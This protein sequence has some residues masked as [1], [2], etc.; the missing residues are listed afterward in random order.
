[1][2]SLSRGPEPLHG[3]AQGI[4]SA[5]PGEDTVGI[6][7]TRA[8]LD[9]A[10]RILFESVLATEELKQRPWREPDHESESRALL[11]LAHHLADSPSTILQ[12]LVN[13]A[14]ET[15][16]AGSAG[17][18]LISKETG[19]FYWPAIAGAWNPHVGGGTPRHFGPCAVVLDADTCQLFKHPE[20]Y[21]PYLA[22]ATP[23]IEEVLL[24]PFHVRGKAV[25]TVWVVSHDPSRRFDAEDQRLLVSLSTF[26]SA[27]YQTLES[28]DELEERRAQSDQDAEKL[29]QSQSDLALELEAT[30]RLQQLGLHLATAGD[31]ES[32]YPNIMDAAIAIMRADFASMQMLYLERGKSGELRLLASRGYSPQAVTAWEWIGADHAT[33]CGVALRTGQRSIVTDVESCD[34]MAGTDDLEMYRQTGVRSLQSTPLVSRAGEVLGMISTC[35]RAPHEPTERDLRLLDLLA[36]QAADWIERLQG[37]E[38]LRLSRDQI[39]RARDLAEA[40]LRTSPV[41]LLVLNADLSVA[42]ANEAFYT[43][44]RV[45]PEETEGRLIYDLGNRQW[46]IPR[47]RELLEAVLPSH[48]SFEGFEVI[49]DFETIGS[50]TMLLNARRMEVERGGPERIILVI[51]DITERKRAEDQVRRAT[52]SMEESQRIARIGSW[53]WDARTDVTSGSPELMRIYGFDPATEVMPDF[54]NQRGLCYPETDWEKINDAV[55]RTLK[56]GEGY[57]LDVCVIRADAQRIW[58]TARSEVVRDDAG[59]IIGLRGTVQDITE[60]KRGEQALRE[61]EERFR[62]LADNMSQLAWTCD[63]FGNVTWYNKRW[64]DY[65][66]LLFDQMKGWDWSKVQHPDHLAR[67]VAGVKRSAETG[68]PWEDTFP[69]RGKDGEYRWFLSRALPI[70]NDAGE[71]VCWFGTNTDVTRLREI[72][73]ALDQARDVAENASRAK[74]KFLAVL[75]HELRTPLTPVLMGVAAMDMNPDLAPALRNDIAMIRRNVELEA[76]L[77]DDLLDLSR[78]TAGKLRLN[79]ESV[80]V[81]SAVRH[82]CETCRPFILEKGIHLHCDLPAVP[83]FVRADSARLQQVLWNLLR[84]SAKFTPERGDIYATI[85]K[86]EDA[87]VRIEVRDTGIGIATNVLPKVFDAFEQGDTNVTKQFGGMGLG[88]AISKAL[89]EAHGGSISAQSAGT[90]HGSTFTVDLPQLARRQIP[91]PTSVQRN[92]HGDAGQLRILV[93]EDHRDTAEVLRRLLQASGHHVRTANSAAS[94]LEL[95]GKEPFDVLVSDIGLPD[96]TGYELMKEIK[97]RYAMIGIA[98]SG[99]GMEDDLLRSRDAGFSDH[100]VKPA[101]VAQLERSIRR[102]TGRDKE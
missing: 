47:L 26:A 59:A 50:R 90:E 9:P 6:Q 33:T 94:A 31:G 84:N 17:V 97:A 95:A 34:W 87:R 15:L 41:P 93:V 7:G 54:R 25:G 4:A 20:R 85:L 52:V 38:A 5:V 21:Y 86:T 58:V 82:A 89:V 91:T 78:V 60:R 42:T 3:F 39:K 99:Y 76:K 53:N 102:L 51:E 63:A 61:S 13:T 57:Q 75:S 62:M 28:L 30:Q 19:D 44:F 88:L 101:N 83:A 56:S 29:R 49:H 35:W 100:I 70:R 36:R 11:G 37:E 74:D 16:G 71:I 32:L 64:L 27:A 55:Q 72:E 18:S 79:M 22:P 98:M 80:D 2:S 1:M 77:I 40:T 81:N 73:Q 43:R 66:G 69:L 92:D 45:P 12:K 23:V 8:A 65:T 68:E 48:N 96:T 10:S 67:V 14:L 46:D 24:S